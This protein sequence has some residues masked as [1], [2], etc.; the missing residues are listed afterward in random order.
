VIEVGLAAGVSV[1][2]GALTPTEV[3]RAWD[4]G[5]SA[6]K[7]FPV[8]AVGGAAYIRALAEPLPDVVV[9]ASGG[10][11][12]SEVEEYLLAGC[13]AVCLGPELVDEQGAAM[14]D[15]EAIA[16]HARSVLQGVVGVAPSLE[17]K[18]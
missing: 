15:A 13:S 8:G 2:P 11:R 17:S 14:R 1:V 7:V 6:V 4:L 10:I 18:R 3:A 12:I 16:K 9:V 5:A